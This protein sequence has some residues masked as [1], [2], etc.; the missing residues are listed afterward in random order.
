VFRFPPY[1][2]L[3][4]AILGNGA[5]LLSLIFCIL[6]LTFIGAYYH[7]YS[8]NAMYTSFIIVYTLTTGISGYV[9]GNFYKQFG[10][11]GWVSNVLL[12]VTLFALPVFVVW[13][14]LNTVALSYQSSAAFPFSKYFL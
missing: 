4:A 13:A 3:L 1:V 2:N 10:G 6:F 5:Q 8:N 14:F 11:E 9:S 7:D 12:T